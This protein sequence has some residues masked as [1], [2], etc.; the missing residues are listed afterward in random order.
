Q[1][2][3][4]LSPKYSHGA[5][6]GFLED[7]IQKLSAIPGVEAVGASS[8]LPLLGT[9][10]VSGL[11]DPDHLQPSAPDNAIANFRFVT[12]GYFQAMGIPLRQGRFLEASDKDRPAA[13]IS[14]RAARFLW[15]SENPIGR[16]VRGAGPSKPALEVV[17]IVGEVRGKVEDAP[18]M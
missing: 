7:M 18:P 15:G 13:V 3:S 2:V 14:E 1:D 16:H 6:L 8:Q 10:W 17:G 9:D 11:R 12:P 4:F 5:R